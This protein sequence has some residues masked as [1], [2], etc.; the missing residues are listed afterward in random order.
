MSQSLLNDRRVVAKRIFDALREKYPD[1]YIALIQPPNVEPLPAAAS[2]IDSRLAFGLNVGAPWP[3]S[4]GAVQNNSAPA[5][6]S[7][8]WGSSLPRADSAVAAK[9]K[10]TGP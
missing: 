7:T 1:K 9:R 8:G 2:K 3:P 5:R 4:R 10:C 6:L